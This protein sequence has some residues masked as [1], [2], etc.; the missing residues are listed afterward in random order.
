MKKD[1][2]KIILA[3]CLSRFGD[4]VE[5]IALCLLCYRM[6]GSVI[7]VGIVSILSALPNILFTLIGGAV[8]EYKEK[9]K[10]MFICEIMRG[11][12]ILAVP[13]LG[14]LNRV[15]V[16]YIVTFLVSTV[17]SFFEPCCSS[18]IS[19]SVEEK[20]YMKVSGISNSAYQIISIIGLAFGGVLVGIIGEYNAFIFDA[21]TFFISAIIVGTIKKCKVADVEVEKRNVVSDI[22]EGIA[23]I[24]KNTKIKVYLLL[25]I[26]VSILVSPLEPYIT[27]IMNNTGKTQNADY[28]IGIMFAILSMGVIVGNL[29]LVYLEKYIKS[30]NRLVTIMVIS[31]ICGVVLLIQK[32]LVIF[33]L[34]ILIIGIVSGCLRTMSISVI[35]TSVDK[36]F[37]ARA[38]SV[39]LL[40]VLCLS[41]L[42]TM[43]ASI[44]IEVNKMILFWTLEIILLGIFTYKYYKSSDIK[45][46]ME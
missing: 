22:K 27:E 13:L 42:A 9:K 10:I 39:V 2:L 33:G 14:F 29:V 20:E 40:L 28:G 16:V 8:S 34:G 41:P 4:N 24:L 21:V 31:S 1:V 32:N 6:T 12:F 35:M 46:Q 23:C 38:S 18:Y 25:L 17:E 44:L 19:C 3:Q 45:E 5:Y 15:E 36:Q 7:P 37:R 11:C 30:K 43:I 26:I